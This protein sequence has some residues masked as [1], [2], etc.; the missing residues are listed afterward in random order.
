MCML[1]VLLVLSE[2]VFLMMSRLSLV[3]L[4][5]CVDCVYSLGCC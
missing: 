1:S 4:S 3:W 5:L 2:I